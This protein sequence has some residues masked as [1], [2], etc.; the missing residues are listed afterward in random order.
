[1]PAKPNVSVRTNNPSLNYKMLGSVLSMAAIALTTATNASSADD[2]YAPVSAIRTVSPETILVP[3]KVNGSLGADGGWILTY[4]NALS[5]TDVPDREVQ[6]RRVTFVDH[7][8]SGVSSLISWEITRT[9]N[10]KCATHALKLCPDM[11]RVLK[12]PDGFL[13]VP[14]SVWVDEGS[15]VRVKI[16]PAVIG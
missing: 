6:S 12:L 7:T 9:Q 14:E 4:S 1:M 15:S 3:L 11:L 8:G 10:N 13:A 16:V 5:D 2:A